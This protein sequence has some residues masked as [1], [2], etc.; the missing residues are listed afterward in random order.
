MF[1]PLHNCDQHPFQ[2]PQ[3]IACSDPHRRDAHCRQPRIARR[4]TFRIVATFMRFTIDLDAQPRRVAIEIE[5]VDARRML[6]PEFEPFG[7][8]TLPETTG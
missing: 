1:C 8:L 6:M 5:L 3:H 4:I 7:P 2:I